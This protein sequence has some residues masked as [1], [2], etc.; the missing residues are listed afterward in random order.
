MISIVFYR[1]LSYLIY[2]LSLACEWLIF[3]LK[4]VQNNSVSDQ[5][6]IAINKKLAQRK[7]TT[8]LETYAA[9]TNHT[10]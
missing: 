6:K 2:V 3:L 10:M 4:S 9:D 5:S 8:R 7:Q 1:F